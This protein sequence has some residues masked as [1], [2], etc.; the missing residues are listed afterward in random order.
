MKNVDPEDRDLSRLFYAPYKC[1]YKFYVKEELQMCLKIKNITHIHFQG[2]S[3]SRDL[4]AAVSSYLGVKGVNEDQLKHLT[5]VM[6]EKKLTTVAD[7]VI[8]SEG[9][10]WDW[11]KEVMDIVNQPPYPQVVVSNFAFAHRAQEP[12][13]MASLFDATEGNFWK[14]DL[15]IE[16]PKYLFHQGAKDLHGKKDRTFLWS[17]DNFRRGNEVLRQKYDTLGFSLLDEFVITNGRLDN[18]GTR[19]DGWHFWGTMRLVCCFV[20]D[21]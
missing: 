1:R 15:K 5:N 9:Y 7:K 14:N 20:F 3:M 12:M 11:T 6:K 21:L 2:D 4:F 19:Q 10:S 17:A 18:Y 13:I 8:L 16:K